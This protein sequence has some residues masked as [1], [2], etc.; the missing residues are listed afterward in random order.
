MQ[1][2]RVNRTFGYHL[3]YL[4]R[5][6]AHHEASD[7]RDRIYALLACANKEYQ[8]RITP[9][10]SNTYIEVYIEATK[11]IIE[12]D[13]SLN[14]LGFPAPEEKSEA[15]LMGAGPPSIPRLGDATV[16]RDNVWKQ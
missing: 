15:L 9:D 5:A 13:K 14:T 10:Y 2:I 1:S 4:L 11:C 7:P 8:Q 12:I 16:Q 3:Y 6:T